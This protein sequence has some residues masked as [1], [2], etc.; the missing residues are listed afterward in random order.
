MPSPS[1]SRCVSLALLL[2]TALL[3]FSACGGGN[4]TPA[5]PSNPMPMVSSLTPS[6]AI[7]GAAATTV[8]VNGSGFVSSSVV[9]WNGAARTTTFV[10]ATELQFLLQASDVASVGSAQISVSNSAPGGGTASPVQITIVYPVLIISSL[11]P[12]AVAAGGPS[13]TLTING[14]GFS[15]TSVVQYN[16]APQATTYVNSS[17]LTTS[18]NAAAPATPTPTQRTPVTAAPRPRPS[19]PAT[20]TV[21]NYPLPVITS[22]TPTSITV[23]SPDTLITIQGTGFTSFSTVQANGTNVTVNSWSP[24]YIFAAVPAAD[25]AAVGMISITVTNPTS[26]VSNAVSI[27]VSPNP[28]PTLSGVSPASAA[29][30]STSFTLLLS[31]SNFVPTSVVQWN[32][33]SRS[34]AFVN[35]NQ[36]TATILATDLQSLGNYNVT[37]FNPAPGGGTS[38]AVVFTTYLSLPANDLVYSASTQH[39]YASVPSIGGPSVGNSIVPIDPYTGVL[40]S[41][42]FVGSEPGRMAISSDGNVIWVALNGAA[43]VRKVDLTTQTA[44]LQFTIGGGTGIYHPQS[45]AHAL[46]VMPG[47]PNTVAVAVPTSST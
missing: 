23:S 4:S 21:D 2:F 47:Q 43:A 41:P 10:S 39:L 12:P 11:N 27:N 14:S 29:I 37:V 38:A 5:P 25:L 17:T 20:P 33:S 42:I 44:G 6:S 19:A 26:L 31:G 3:W 13:I 34:T 40:G 1:L 36:L 24:N 18:V 35:G 46:A 30:G 8:T 28:V 15:P 9:N 7:A 16:S 32:G 45:T 22:V